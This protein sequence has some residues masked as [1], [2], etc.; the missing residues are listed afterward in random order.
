MAM[1]VFNLLITSSLTN[2]VRPLTL[3]SSRLMKDAKIL[4]P[5]FVTMFLKSQHKKTT[6]TT[7]RLSISV[8]LNLEAVYCPEN[9][10]LP[11]LVSTC[12]SR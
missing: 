12:V 9:K 1:I 4:C 11:V 8:A 10:S 7:R 6:A 2:S 5:F 3:K